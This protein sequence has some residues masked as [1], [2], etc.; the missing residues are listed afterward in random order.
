MRKVICITFPRSG[1][2]LLVNVI[3]KY[4]SGNVEYSETKGEMAESLC[5]NVLTA[6]ELQYCEFYNHCKQTPCSDPKTNFQKNHDFYLELQPS[7]EFFYIILYRH[8]LDSLVSLYNYCLLNTLD[9]FL[10]SGVNF[11]KTGWENFARENIIFWKNFVGKWII[12]RRSKNK[13][14]ISYEELTDLPLIS[15][16]NIIKFIDPGSAVN[17]EL[18]E[19]AI[20]KVGTSK[21][22]D[23]RQF[24]YYHEGFFSELEKSALTELKLLG[25]DAKLN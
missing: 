2:H 5:Q 25:I 8:P 14:F 3:L 24:Q 10:G 16:I 22:H 9:V 20:K 13:L 11:N 1:H 19:S 7:D 23:I 17:L 6:G 4:F 15:F 18:L 21:R 12:G